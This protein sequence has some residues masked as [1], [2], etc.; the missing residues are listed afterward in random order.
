MRL[1]RIASRFVYSSPQMGLLFHALRPKKERRH[2]RVV[3]APR[4]NAAERL[5]VLCFDF[6]AVI[7]AYGEACAAMKRNGASG[8]S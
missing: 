4:H 3:A 5:E 8:E 1:V 7:L 2:T 6:R